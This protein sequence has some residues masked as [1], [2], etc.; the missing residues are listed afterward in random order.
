MEKEKNRVRNLFILS[1]SIFCVLLL[2]FSYLAIYF[3]YQDKRT[4]ITS[5]MDMITTYTSQEYS[6]I[7]SNFWQT[8]MPIF[9]EAEHSAAISNLFSSDYD[10]SP[11]NKKNLS[12]LL[13][14][15][16]LRD[17]RISWI[18][19]YSSDRTHNYIQYV[20]NLLSKLM[21]FSTKLNIKQISVNYV[22]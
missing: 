21:K 16:S 22:H 14:K 12:E 13:S 3:S 5:S 9:A 2:F 8:Y 4:R 15:M 19:L 20:I 6:D 1:T 7:V 11:Y 17:D 18:A 10:L